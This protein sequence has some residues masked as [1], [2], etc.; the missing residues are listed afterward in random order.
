[1]MSK[2]FSALDL[3]VW[4]YHSPFPEF[5]RWTKI[6]ID[7]FSCDH[8]VGK[9][10]FDGGSVVGEQDFFNAHKWGNFLVKVVFVWDVKVE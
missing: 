6:N 7:N 2:Y 8:Y 5:L 1:M 4:V 9:A 10:L 3:R